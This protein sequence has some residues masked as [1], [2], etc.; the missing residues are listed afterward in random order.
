MT[1]I[2]KNTTFI[3]LDL[4]DTIYKEINFVKS[5]FTAIIKKYADYHHDKYFEVMMNSWFNGSNAIKT[6]FE[7][8]N[9]L[10]IPIKEPL[11]LYHSHFPEI[12]LPQESRFF[13]Q[14]A[15]SRGYKLGL[16]TDGRTITQRNKLKSLGIDGFFEKIVISEEFG[17]E[18]PTIQNYKIFEESFPGNSFCY[19]G[20]NLK[21]DFI[22][23]AKLG[24]KMYCIRD[25]GINIHRQDLSQVSP[26]IIILENINQFFDE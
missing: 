23:P 24:W 22:A 16:I 5:G 13:F 8:L 20:D 19:I 7:C 26:E 18:K 1:T 15:L 11:N 4:D 6:L 25:S 10:N 21:K 3:V 12:N 14:T 9:I 2:N 17:S